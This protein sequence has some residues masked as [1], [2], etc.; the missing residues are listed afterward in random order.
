MNN[1]VTY[2]PAD[3][4]EGSNPQGAVPPPSRKRAG[5]LR[6]LSGLES[7]RLSKIQNWRHKQ[8]SSQHTLARQKK[9]TKEKH[10]NEKIPPPP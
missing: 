1:I 2:A 7:R 6:Q 3:G 4:L 5:L 8:R 9:Y 10:F